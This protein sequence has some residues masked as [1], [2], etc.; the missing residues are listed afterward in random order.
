[1]MNKF[2]II[3]GKAR[4][5]IIVTILTL[6]PLATTAQIYD[7][8]YETSKNEF[9]LDGTDELEE[10]ITH[11]GVLNFDP[12]IDADDV[13]NAFIMRSD[14]ICPDRNQSIPCGVVDQV[15][16][17]G[18]REELVKTLA[19]DAQ[20]ITAGYEMP[21]GDFPIGSSYL[22]PRFASIIKIWQSTN[23]SLS[24]N[25]IENKVV[26]DVDTEDSDDCS[27]SPCLSSLLDD[28]GRWA[29]RYRWGVR[30][31][32]KEFAP[33]ESD[34]SDWENWWNNYGPEITEVSYLRE[35]NCDLET[36]LL[37][38]VEEHD[39]HG[40][41]KI[42]I[43][44]IAGKDVYVWIRSHNANASG[45]AGLWNTIPYIPQFPQI[46]RDG[47]PILGGRYAEPPYEPKKD[48]K[49]CSQ[50]FS[51]DG[52]LCRPLSTN[53][54]SESSDPNEMY[55][56]SCSPENLK[57]IMTRRTF[58]GMDSCEVGGWRT[59]DFGFRVLDP[60]TET[61][62]ICKPDDNEE[63][64]ESLLPDDCDGIEPDAPRQYHCGNCAVDLY[65]HDNA[66]PDDGFSG[67]ANSVL[68]SP[69]NNHGVIPVCIPSMTTHSGLYY[70]YLAGLV[71]AQS[72]CNME[73]G[74][75][76]FIGSGT[77]YG[78]GEE[79]KK[80]CC[81]ANITSARVM[82]NALAED[83]NFE[84][85]DLSIEECSAVYANKIC[86]IYRVADPNNPGEFIEACT[87]DNLNYN[88]MLDIETD[89][90]LALHENA[91]GRP[92][93]CPDLIEMTYDDEKSRP[94]MVLR[95][96]PQVCSPDCEAKYANT[97]GNNMCYVSQ[98][99]EQTIEEHRRIGG[100]WGF[101][102][103][104]QSF[105][106]DYMARR[107]PIIGTVLPAPP[108][109]Q[110]KIPPYR[111]EMLALKLDLALCQLNGLPVM[112]PPIKCAFQETKRLNL[113]PAEYISL[114]TGLFGQKVSNAIASSG[115]ETMAQ[116]LGSRIGTSLYESYLGFS[117]RAFSELMNSANT[118]LRGV[119]NVNFSTFMCPRK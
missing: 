72:I 43:K 41:V 58:W 33:D 101:L 119:S 94:G 14:L 25:A 68:V 61:W 27:P 3:K 66:E 16:A 84:D 54:C 15:K 18:T 26:F 22:A 82:C 7:Y 74:T 36:K 23:D 117:T 47:E 9:L 83:G 19:R 81:T 80:D 48:E 79:G 108:I 98:C 55:L 110:V 88:Q 118:L 96:L 11:G 111:A 38:M 42:T 75:R 53:L 89:I 105:P 45:D 44:K 116:S 65:C 50:V 21:I 17:V 103:T 63:A 93:S 86:S 62:K 29:W 107:D 37:S 71:Q 51:S 69:K 77:N 34:C 60:G 91:A 57:S 35:R 112:Y 12:P 40:E 100:R 114:G 87:G 5:L 73:M 31:I 39:V 85:L 8:F 1:M 4:N 67:C 95:S 46:M 104:D 92:T 30:S 106:W 56:T 13:K 70:L 32:Q 52:Y 6:I 109:P 99:V 10:F 20:I 76:P 64:N 28:E 78:H 102:S 59:N 24:T 97:I 90:A 49:L 113:H 2:S 115:L